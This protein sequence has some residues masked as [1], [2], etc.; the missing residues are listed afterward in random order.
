MVICIVVIIILNIFIFW[1]REQDYWSRRGPHFANFARFPVCLVRQTILLYPTFCGKRKVEAC[2]YSF[3]TLLFSL[4]E[5]EMGVWDFMSSSMEQNAP[6]LSS[7]KNAC[8]SSYKY[9]SYAV[10]KIDNTVRVNGIQ[11]FYSYWPDA[12]A[13]DKI[14][15]FAK[16]FTANTADYAMHE[17]IKLLPGTYSLPQSKPL[18]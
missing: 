1:K 7:V 2:Y 18:N 6:N 15:L 8:W 9:T 12:E 16:I 3:I 4:R 14:G 13:R 10:K 11:R 5:R 17:G